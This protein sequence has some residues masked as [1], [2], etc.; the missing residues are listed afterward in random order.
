M[1]YNYTVW[2]SHY[3]YTGTWELAE[4]FKTLDD[5]VDYIKQIQLDGYVIIDMQ[6]RDFEIK[7]Q[8]KMRVF[9]ICESTAYS[10]DKRVNQAIEMIEA[11]GGKVIN[12]SLATYSEWIF[13]YAMILYEGDLDLSFQKRQ[14]K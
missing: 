1:G 2:A 8:D 11:K 9:T 5:A 14:V 6:I 13:L 7:G 4:D 10:L 3:P 12:V